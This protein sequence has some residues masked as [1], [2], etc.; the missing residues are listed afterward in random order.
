MRVRSIG[1]WKWIGVAVLCACFAPSAQAQSPTLLGGFKDWFAYTS[2]TGA[3]RTCYAL[4][5]PKS[6]N[7]KGANRDPA[8]FLISTFPGRKVANEPSFVAGY[9]YKDGT[10][11]RLQVGS[12][13]F[14]FFTKNDGNA[15]GAWS[16]S[17]AEERRLI[18]SMRRGSQLV[19]TGTSARGTLTRDTFSLSGIS[20]A[21]DRA[22]QAC[23]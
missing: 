11:A 15:G 19:I 8:F 21:L 16:D 18:D 23:Q 22:A 7:P 9:P 5:E 13:K 20:A 1:G 3:N 14:D 4:S 2:G 10:K 6:S 12:D 17:P